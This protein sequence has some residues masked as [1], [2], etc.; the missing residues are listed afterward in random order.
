VPPSA[1][2]GLCPECML[3]LGAASQ[4]DTGDEAGPHGTR[5]VPS[6]PAKPE[7]IGKH[8]PQ[9][10]ILECLGRGGMGVVYKARQPRL[11]R[12]VA[13]K[14]LAPEKEQ[15][16]KFAERFAREAKAL[17]R[18]NHPNIVTV[19]DFGEADG[20]FYLL[21]EYVDGVT[22]R[23]LLQT[24]KIAPE[25]ALSIVPK[26]CDALQFAHELGVV[27]RDIKPENVLLDKQGRLKIAD[28]GIA[29]IVQGRDASPRRL[30]EM[31]G[32]LGQPSSQLSLKR[33]R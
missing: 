2:Q 27:H 15:D 29:K 1:L 4:T 19:H 10:E 20:M 18:L 23:Q 3:A 31:S 28:F 13:L 6:P 7:E 26:I 9:L 16:P 30:G 25:E 33:A 17:A 21:M 12:L 8:F 5:V 14:I 32:R 22:L 11:D 24:R